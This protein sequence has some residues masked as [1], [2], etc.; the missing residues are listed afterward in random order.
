MNERDDYM[1]VEV[2]LYGDKTKGS[3]Q[4]IGTRREVWDKTDYY[5]SWLMK[6][7]IIGSSVSFKIIAR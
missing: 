7:G 3:T 6:F 2:M 4:I 1:E 5:I